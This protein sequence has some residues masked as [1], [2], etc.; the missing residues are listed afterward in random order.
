MNET[1]MLHLINNYNERY[2]NTWFS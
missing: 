1:D 2:H